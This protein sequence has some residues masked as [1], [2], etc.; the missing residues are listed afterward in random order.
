MKEIRCIYSAILKILGINT[1]EIDN[2][3]DTEVYSFYC[4]KLADPKASFWQ[5]VYEK[6]TYKEL[7]K[8]I[9]MMKNTYYFSH[10]AHS[11]IN[12]LNYDYL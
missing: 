4:E 6:L 7:L 10:I 3:K 12:Q 5:M 11:L 8:I 1:V 2:K 9:G